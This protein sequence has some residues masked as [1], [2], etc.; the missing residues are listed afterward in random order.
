MTDELGSEVCTGT[1]VEEGWTVW[2]EDTAA[3]D[4]STTFVIAA[5]FAVLETSTG[6]TEPEGA[7]SELVDATTVPV[8][9][10][11]EVATR[12]LVADAEDASTSADEEDATT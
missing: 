12:P 6:D 10:G 5:G 11:L 9:R 7:V 4:G 2:D 3:D 8:G 1:D